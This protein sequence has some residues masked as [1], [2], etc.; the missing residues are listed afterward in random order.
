MTMLIDGRVHVAYAIEP[1]T[2][3]EFMVI[4]MIRRRGPRGYQMTLARGMHSQLPADESDLDAAIKQVLHHPE[5]VSRHPST[6]SP[7]VC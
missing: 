1:E 2:A 5:Q 3:D 4:A 6:V 7:S